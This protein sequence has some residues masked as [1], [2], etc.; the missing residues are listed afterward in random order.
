[1]N[2]QVGNQGGK[3]R[4]ATIS[5]A[6]LCFCLIGMFVWFL[7]L[8]AI[9]TLIISTSPM[10]TPNAFDSFNEAVANMKDAA[11]IDFA[12]QSFHSG[13]T[14]DDRP[15]SLRER[16]KLITENAP[17]LSLFREGMGQEYMAPSIRSIFTLQPYLSKYRKLTRLLILNSQ[18]QA[19]KGDWNCAVLSRLDAIEFGNKILT[20]GALMHSLVGNA[21]ISLGQRGISPLF[22]M[23]ST[24]QTKSAL[25]RLEKIDRDTYPLSE[26]LQEEKRSGQAQI[27]EVYRRIRTYKD[28]IEL[29]NLS[30]GN[31]IDN[32]RK[33]LEYVLMD[34]RGVIDTYARYMDSIIA[35]SNSPYDALASFPVVPKDPVNQLL[36]SDPSTFSTCI[37]SSKC[38]IAA[39]RMFMLE[40]A[41]KI[42]K[43]EH[44]KYPSSLSQVV[45]DI[46]AKLPNDPFAPM[47][48]FKYRLNK[49]GYVLYSL[50]PDGKDD[51]GTPIDDKSKISKQ[52]PTSTAR[53]L[54]S[55]E[56]KG[57][58][59]LGT[60][61]R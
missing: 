16:Q 51:G 55:E 11:K 39:D 28:I 32:N 26:T 29:N 4:N 23:L 2:M 20:G 49:S 45:P 47:N 7:R 8:T 37:C 34:K 25:A 56:S 21:C 18:I 48:S 50:G 54:P 46:L 53:Y 57:D 3:K 22:K 30:F 43:D 38:L 33:V 40:L 61:V 52:F 6:I 1:M 58:I 42:Y 60:N 35:I 14:L 5:F 15:Y 36:D 44:G 12:S 24:A 27:L 9:P 13:K 41:L 31:P 19:E 10:P 17:V 59:V